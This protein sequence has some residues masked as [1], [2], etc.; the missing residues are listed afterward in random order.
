[1]LRDM[2]YQTDGTY[3]PNESIFDC[4]KKF[5]LEHQEEL[6][7]KRMNARKRFNK[8]GRSLID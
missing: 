1:M 4:E 6:R 7:E 2:Q 5:W 3:Y 8:K